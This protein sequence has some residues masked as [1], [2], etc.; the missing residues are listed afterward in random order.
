M[1]KIP[2]VDDDKFTVIEIDEAEHLRQRAG[3]GWVSVDIYSW[4]LSRQLEPHELGR[5]EDRV[6]V[7]KQQ[8]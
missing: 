6:Y 2:L 5:V 3:N 1:S 4:S 8:R 7:L